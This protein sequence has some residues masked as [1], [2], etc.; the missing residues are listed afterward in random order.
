MNGSMPKQEPVRHDFSKIRSYMALPN[1]IDVQRK[2]YE[3]FLQMN[4]L[5]EE[6]EDTG[7]QSVFT[8]V[9]P[10]SDFRE[11]CSLDFVRFSIGNWECKCGQ[12]KGLE[13][14]RMSCAN[15]GAKIITDHPHEE[16]VNCGQCGVI[17][18]NR[19]EVCDICGNPVDLQMKYSV[20]ECQERGMT[21]SVPLKVTFRLFVYDKD[22]D[23]GVKHMRDAKE[24]EVFFG[25]IPLMTDNGTFV[26]NGTERVI[27]SQLHRSPG[28]FFTKESAHT[29]LAKIIPYRGSW[30]EFEYD[31]KNILYVRIDRK[32]KFLG[33]VFLRA[34]GM[35][36][37]EDILR[38]F[39][40]PIRARVSDSGA[41]LTFDRR[42]LDQE[43]AKE[44]HSIRG[45]RAVRT[46]FAGI[47]LDQKMADALTKHNEATAAVEYGALD[48]AAFLADV[49]DFNTGEVLFEAGEAVP[50]DWAETLRGHGVAEV[51]VIFPDWDL[52]SDI[53]LNTVRKDTSKSF[54]ASIIEIYRRMRPGDPPTLESAKALFEGMFFDSRKYDFSRVGRFK[55]NI[56]L[57]LDSPVTQKTMTPDDFYVVINYLL[58]LRKDVGRVDD[59]DN[60][61]NRR[62]RAVGELLENQFRIGLVRMERAIKEKMSVHQD[63]DSAMP[64]DLINSK[65]V[66]A[67]IKEFFGSSQLS[68]F[69]DQTNPLSEV[70]HK[71]RLSALGPGG[72]SRERAGFEVRDVHP[73]H[74]GRICP[75]ET[76]E[77]PNIGLI[78][79]LACYARINEYG[80]IE[81]PYKKV[82]DGRVLDH[83]RI[84]KAGDT[85]F[86][87]GQIVEKRDLQKENNR[88]AKENAAAG[89]K[90]RKGLLQAAEAEPYAFYLSAWDEERY[91]IAQ[92]NVIMDDDGN[93]LHDRVIARQSGD[94]VSIEKEK[95]DFIDVSPKQLVSV[96]A[97]LVPFLENDDANRALMG[98]N[99]QR[100]SV[101]LLRTQSPLVGTGMENVVARDSGAVVMC[102]RG[103]VVD[104][105]D[106]NRIIVR[107]EAEDQ[108]TG[109]TKEFGADIYQLIKFKRSNQNTCITQKPVV[110]EGQ[111][112]RKGQ[113]LADGPCTDA[114]ELALGRN[115][116]VAFMPWRGNNFEDAILVSEK[117][118]RD[119]YYTSIHI[120]EF[121]IEA[122]DTKLGPEE[123]TRDIPNVSESALRDLDES[124]I[125][126]IGA[127]VKQGD[128]LV[129]KVTPKGETQ[130]TP[131]EK[132]LRAIFGEKAGD[133]RDASLKTPPGIEGTVVDVKIFSRKGVDK[134]MRAKSIE[135]GEIE[136]M[137]RN[138]QDEIRII[139]EARNKKIADL[140]AD[141]KL[142]RD[143]VDFK[144]G[145]VLIRKGESADRDVISRLSRRELLALPVE[146]EIRETI[147]MFVERGENRIRVLEQKAEERREDL[148]KGDELPPGVIKMI[149]VYVAMKRKLSV[150]DKMAGRHGNKGVI[151]RILPEEDMPYM[152]DGTP[153][154][155]VLNPLGVPSRM[156]VGQI[157]ETH[158]GWAA[159]ALGLHFS[160]PV[161]DGATE[162]EIKAQLTAA[163]LPTEGKTQLFDGMTGEPFEQQVCVGYIY[164][165]KLSH[166][167][168]DKIHARSIGPYSL[169][170]QQPLGG[171]AQFGGQRFGEMEVWALEAYGAAYTL[172]E[173]LTVKSDDVEGRSKVY[174]SIV[175]GEVPDDPGLPESFNVLVRELQ[176][177]CL[178]VEL[179]KE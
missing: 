159:N 166:L 128:I 37:D 136:R 13:H 15:C 80:F 70:T 175:K 41:T 115:V 132:L 153:V 154:E 164:M 32:R 95:V 36:T 30:V 170:T 146:E 23:T 171:K 69:M 89:S 98:A 72:L 176:S 59:I 1:L 110:R 158:L 16:T 165:L 179:L 67:A 86:Q 48:K 117:M 104:L 75:I 44:R 167:V 120:E 43:E 52:V 29:F 84:V 28:V 66:I 142:Q 27:V 105:V 4:L 77:G 11:T 106:S 173:L 88:V 60:L 133:V 149:K 135:D 162:S 137:N 9:F 131:E 138:I 79:S 108:E 49:V 50:A 94:F 127:T 134:D 65:P 97:S 118:V 71:R 22:P 18:K 54:E 19:V 81:S 155:I 126:R 163:M 8:S 78:S 61:G 111:R 10:F 174:E 107:V 17:N 91:T 24:E 82:Q 169:I 47:R 20:E 119:D 113:V 62:V 147:R 151:S 93:L 109:Q 38:Q 56:K 85:T 160:T 45:R 124:G 92:A 63:I 141:Q 5:P 90:S 99:M 148:Q 12:L 144:T 168:D 100:Q 68:Q 116:L 102:K 129:G 58:R 73:T 130:L 64:H 125:I 34:L 152:P 2:S 6:R 35:T 53:L 150:G 177:L 178:D 74:Y 55:F 156:N 96:A 14:L 157:L 26:I 161:F 3:R 46:I 7:L 83:Y 33:S 140:L 172:Q 21:Y 122:R 42:V 76:P 123:I 145:D 143:V 40:T 121:E 114:G 31:Q 103:G 25:D 139:T 57:D 101:P 112:V 39:Y 51:E 87:L